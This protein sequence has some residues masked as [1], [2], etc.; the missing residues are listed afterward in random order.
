MES[1]ESLK[2]ASQHV[3]Y[4]AVIIGAI[5]AGIA[6]ILTRVEKVKLWQ[7]KAMQ[8]EVRKVMNEEYMPLVMKKAECESVHKLTDM[9]AH[10]TRQAIAELRKSNETQHAEVKSLLQTLIEGIVKQKLGD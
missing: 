6:W 4:T 7:K 10:Y 3:T 9:N 8:G 2:L 5:S 1:A